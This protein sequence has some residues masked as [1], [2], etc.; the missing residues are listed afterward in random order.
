M[1]LIAHWLI[2]QGIYQNSIQMPCS[3]LQYLYEHP[4]AYYILFLNYMP[5]HRTIKNIN[6]EFGKYAY[7]VVFI[8]IILLPDGKSLKNLLI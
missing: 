6:N 5:S 2:N 7:F 8:H 4:Q 3:V 1:V